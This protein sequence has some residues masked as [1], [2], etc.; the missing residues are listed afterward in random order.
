MGR[1][2]KVFDWL[3]VEH[4][5]KLG[6]KLCQKFTVCSSAM[7][8]LTYITCKIFDLFGL[9]VV[10]LFT[11]SLRP[12]TFCV[13]MKQACLRHILTDLSGAERR[14]STRRKFK[15]T[16]NLDDVNW[17]LDAKQ[18]FPW[19]KPVH[20][21]VWVELLQCPQRWLPRNFIIYLFQSWDLEPQDL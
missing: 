14:G 7:S 13:R 3:S 17:D 18:L 16:T 6:K 10:F 21:L 12:P 4:E 2:H 19:V 9:A 8:L 11:S 5:E 15:K 20:A 1:N